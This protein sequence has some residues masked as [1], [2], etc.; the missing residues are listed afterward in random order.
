MEVDTQTIKLMNSARDVAEYFRYL[1]TYRA[2]DVNLLSSMGFN[3][4]ALEFMIDRLDDMAYRMEQKLEIKRLS[5][6]ESQVK[7][8]SL[9]AFRHKDKTDGSD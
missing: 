9:D 6:R 3:L 5:T 7:I 8:I 4:T 1:A 2:N